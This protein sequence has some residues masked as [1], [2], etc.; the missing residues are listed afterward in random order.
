LA[1]QLRQIFF[2]GDGLTETG[3]GNQ[4][5]FIVPPTATRLYLG[6]PD[7]PYKDN[8][9]SFTATFTISSLSPAPVPS[10]EPGGFTTNGTLQLQL[11]GLA[12]RSYILQASTNLSNWVSIGTNIPVVT[13][14]YTSDP[15]A[16]NYLQRFYRLLSP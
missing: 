12:G 10:L 15:A 1:P 4:Q 5:T 9:G 14:F 6:I 16:I 8:S 13:P 7:N 11:S 3:S 2:I